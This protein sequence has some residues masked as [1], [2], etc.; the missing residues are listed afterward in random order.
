[1]VAALPFLVALS[2][3]ACGSDSG[4]CEGVATGEL[5]DQ[6]GLLFVVH[7]E[8][9]VEGDLLEVEATDVIWFTDRPRRCAG[10][11]ATDELAE[12]W[13]AYGFGEDPPNAAA[14]G[15][16]I[17]AV[18]EL[19]DP[20]E[21]DGVLSFTF[22]TIQGDLGGIEGVRLSVFIDAAFKGHKD[23]PTQIPTD[24]PIGP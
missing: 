17:E 8:A 7:G 24:E 23:N 21:S 6:S 15:P 20:E 16:E 11:G 13:E 2:L 22:R 4:A 5:P 1:M 9:T 10:I 12:K 19:G 14:I 3:T 18:V